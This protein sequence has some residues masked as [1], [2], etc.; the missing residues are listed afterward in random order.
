MIAASN[1]SDV[2]DVLDY[3]NKELDPLDTFKRNQV[4]LHEAEMKRQQEIEEMKKSTQNKKPVAFSFFRRWTVNV[5]TVILI[6]I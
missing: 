2:R 6:D 1:V 3:Y 4:K 5:I